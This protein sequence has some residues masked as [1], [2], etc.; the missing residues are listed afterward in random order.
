MIRERSARARA[1][2]FDFE[3]V[4][5]KTLAPLVN[6]P[7]RKRLSPHTRRE[8]GQ[9]IAQPDRLKSPSGRGIDLANHDDA[10]GFERIDGSRQQCILIGTRHHVQHVEQ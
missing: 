10:T 9:T 8:R 7:E 3:A 2:T 5:H 4:P 1:R 6:R